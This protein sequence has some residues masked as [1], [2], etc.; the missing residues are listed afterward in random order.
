[1]PTL[2]TSPQV[3]GETTTPNPDP[4]SNGKQHTR[5]YAWYSDVSGNTCTVHFKLTVVYENVSYT[6]TNKFRQLAYDGYD[7]G[8]LP[9][10]DAPLS[11]NVEY[12]VLEGSRTYNGGNTVNTSALYWSNVYRSSDI[13]NCQA[14]VPVFA[15]PPTGLTLSNTSD[16]R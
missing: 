4:Q 7:S 16:K 12:L 5:L 11:A 9:Y 3:L 13:G 8:T 6:G 15:T 10:T 2:T 14:T 1:M